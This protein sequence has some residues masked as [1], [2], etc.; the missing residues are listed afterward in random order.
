[1]RDLLPVLNF[2]GIDGDESPV[3][4]APREFERQMELLA[5]RGYAVIPFREALD[6][7][8]RPGALPGRTA[9]LTFDDGLESVY[10]AALP[11]LKAHGFRATVFLVTGAEGNCVSWEREES[12]SSGRLLDAGQVR[13]LADSGFEIGAHT[14]THPHLTDLEDE[15]LHREVAGSRDDVAE[16]AGS[17]PATFA[18]PYGDH[19]ER[20]VE[21]VR[22][23]GFSGACTVELPGRRMGRDLF[24]VERFDTSRFSGQVGKAGEL[25]F[26]SCLNGV[27]ADYLRVKKSLPLF[28]T[29]TFEYREKKRRPRHV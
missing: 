15:E 29:H 24:R 12:I 25:F 16:I 11:V 6:L 20:V 21:A 26:L 1:M 3:S 2:H 13:E 27:F 8:A 7:L 19:D 5:E 23:A 18:Y 10:S 14:R 4:L 22:R 28:R 9:A 17:A